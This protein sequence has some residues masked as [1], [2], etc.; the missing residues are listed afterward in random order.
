MN[1]KWTIDEDE[2]LKSNYPS[3]GIADCAEHLNKTQKALRGRLNRLQIPVRGD[4]YPNSAK[5]KGK[6]THY[7]REEDINE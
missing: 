3:I 6:T 7:F 1:R 2:W 4:L 5:G